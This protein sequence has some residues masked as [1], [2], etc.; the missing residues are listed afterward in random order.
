LNLLRPGRAVA[1]AAQIG[2]LIHATLM[3][4][5]VYKYED[6][7]KFALSAADAASAVFCYYQL[8]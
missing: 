4:R 6:N 7:V 1:I 2:G 5:N 8:D 3:F